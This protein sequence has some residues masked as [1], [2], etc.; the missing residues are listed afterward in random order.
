MQTFRI[1]SATTTTIVSK[2]TTN[3]E[4]RAGFKYISIA[5]AQA[6]NLVYVDLYLDDGTNQTYYFKKNLLWPGES[7][8][9]DEEITFDSMQHGLKLTTTTADSSHGVSVNVIIN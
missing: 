3:F 2:N 8:F 5:N 6:S 1:T 4:T 9:M 7:I